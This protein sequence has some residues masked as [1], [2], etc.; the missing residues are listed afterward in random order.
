MT[1]ADALST[2]SR[3]FTTKKQTWEAAVTGLAFGAE[4]AMFALGDGSV[5]FWTPDRDEPRVVQAHKGAILS[6]VPD[7]A[8]A[9]LL[10]GGDDGAV[11]HTQ[12][13]GTSVC[14]S[15]GNKRWI[16]HVALA[17]WGAIAWSQGK[18]VELA[19]AQGKAARTI[20]LPSSCGG[21]AFS[22]KG[23]R[24][25]V[26]HYGGAT[27]A[28]LAHPRA[29]PE[30]LDWKG[31][32]LAVAWSPDARFLVTGT[33][34]AAL[35][36]WWLRDKRDLHF[37]GYRTKPRSLVWDPRGRWLATSG[38]LGVLLW[39]LE[40]KEAPS[41][42]ITAQLGQ[43]PE[44]AT[45]IAWH[46]RSPI[47]AVGYHDGVVL[48]AEHGERGGV[49]FLRRDDGTPVTALAWKPDGSTLA[50]GTGS[51]AA[52]LVDCARMRKGMP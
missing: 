51:G 21:L 15:S 26:A 14:I 28:S 42:R 30:R 52:G 49:L 40:G 9:G 27:I 36:V 24:L 50:F 41:A 7:G 5:R 35:H 23:E 17:P 45:A 11:M 8:A 6:A 25:A 46:P 1:L 39:T 20:E 18:T 2:S 10:T 34:E 3:P 12:C 29:A 38:H 22:P 43:R 13:D 47:L 44:V 31:S 19:K 32:H 33:Q 4:T 48:L 37:A 16:D